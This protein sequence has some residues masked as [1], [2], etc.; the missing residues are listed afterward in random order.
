MK[1]P[2]NI[3]FEIFNELPIEKRTEIILHENA[4]EIQCLQ[5]ELGREKENH[6]KKVHYLNNRINRIRKEILDKLNQ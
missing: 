6:K 5:R 1:T 4:S 3:V 2:E